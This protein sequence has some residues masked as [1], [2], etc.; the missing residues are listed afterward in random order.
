MSRVR[1]PEN[2]SSATYG[3]ADARRLAANCSTG[4]P[5]SAGHCVFCQG[6]CRGGFLQACKRQRYQ[7]NPNFLY[8]AIH[9]ADSLSGIAFVR[10]MLNAES[11]HPP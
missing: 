5:W 7:T 8:C 11:W 9:H 10:R 6:E 4:Q 3:Y 1:A 2:A